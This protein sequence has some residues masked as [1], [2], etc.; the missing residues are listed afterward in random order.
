MDERRAYSRR[1]Q[2]PL[3]VRANGRIFESRDW[4]EGNLVLDSEGT[5]RI[6]AMI[7]ID[8]VGLSVQGLA[9]IEV[10]GRVERVTDH[11]AAV[12]NFLHRDD[13]AAIVLR[14]LFESC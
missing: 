2:P 13:R 8:A 9:P 3:Q 4:S 11:G 14:G 10:R 6:G 12:V 1:P 5:Y 7:T